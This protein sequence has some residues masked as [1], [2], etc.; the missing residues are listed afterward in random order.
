MGTESARLCRLHSAG[1]QLIALDSLL[2]SSNIALQGDERESLLLF[3]WRWG[4][5]GFGMAVKPKRPFVGTRPCFVCSFPSLLLQL[6]CC[7]FAHRQRR[8]ASPGYQ[9]NTFLSFRKQGKQ[10]HRTPSPSQANPPPSLAFPL[11]LASPATR[12]LDLSRCGPSQVSHSYMGCLTNQHKSYDFSAL[13][14]VPFH[15]VCPI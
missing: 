11:S 1:R 4:N 7:F 9:T 13:C 12:K 5:Y 10:M 3:R 6:H 14:P 8:E 15:V 2:R